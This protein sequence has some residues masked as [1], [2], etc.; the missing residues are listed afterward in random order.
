VARDELAHGETW[1][2]S[3]AHH[4]VQL[5]DYSA[6]LLALLDGTRD[7]EAVVAALAPRVASG[8]LAILDLEHRPVESEARA[9]EVLRE[10]WARAL[11]SLRYYGLL[12]G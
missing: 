1:V 6:A 4:G 7:R 9:A 8:E 10:G 2:T 5:D 11:R 12:E 3:R